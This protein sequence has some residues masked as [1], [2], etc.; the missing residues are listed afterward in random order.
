MT[1][2]D[3][4]RPDRTMWSPV[5]IE[6]AIHE[7]SNE[8]AESV[9]V[10]G[11]LYRR[12]LDTDRVYDYEFARAYLAAQGAVVAR[13]YMAEV[14]TIRQREDRDLADASY[15]LADR[16]SRALQEK[17]RALQSVGAS[18]RSQYGVAGRGEGY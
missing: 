10:C 15:R 8:I 11:D 1:G 18:I 2:Q 6:T 12:F 13:K 7:V 9:T 16:R 14:A 5:Q 4:Y 3:D 17:L